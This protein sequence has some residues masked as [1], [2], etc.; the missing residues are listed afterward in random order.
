MQTAHTSGSAP[1][2]WLSLRTLSCQ[3]HTDGPGAHDALRG[4]EM[5]MTDRQG[6]F[7]EK[8]PSQPGVR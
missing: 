6:G 4:E 5:V 1:E 2:A 8:V 7:L 3:G